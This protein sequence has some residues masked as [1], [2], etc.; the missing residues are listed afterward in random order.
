[1]RYYVTASSAAED[2]CGGYHVPRNLPWSGDRHLFDNPI[3]FIA[4]R[5]FSYHF[6]T[7]YA[8]QRKDHEGASYGD[9]VILYAHTRNQFFVP[10]SISN[11]SDRLPLALEITLPQ[12]T[13]I[14]QA[15]GDNGMTTSKGQNTPLSVRPA[16]LD[17]NDILGSSPDISLY[18]DIPQFMARPTRSMLEP[19]NV[20]Q[21]DESWNELKTD[22]L[23]MDKL[24]VPSITSPLSPISKVMSSIINDAPQEA[25]SG[26]AIYVRA[27]PQILEWDP[28]MMEI[29]QHLLCFAMQG[30]IVTV[31]TTIFSTSSF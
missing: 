27:L 21:A 4:I 22:Y 15:N 14:A 1:L 10:T 13:S 7:L 28:V 25:E 23:V 19:V 18:P 6:N 26:L 30:V 3:Y 31:C 16:T 2:R 20:I 8:S 5:G 29:I 17:T 9:S 24:S 12:Y 11:A